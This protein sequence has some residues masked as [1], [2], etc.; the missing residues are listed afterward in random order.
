LVQK[1]RRQTTLS[2]D[3]VQDL[4][5]VRIDA[6][7]TLHEQTALANEIA[8]HF[9]E[10]SRVKDLREN[11]HSGYR[12]VHVW[13][14]L[15]AGRAEIQVRTVM[16]SAWANMYEALGDRFGRG[17]R[18]DEEAPND[19]AKLAVETMHT[20]SDSLASIENSR[21]HT[22]HEIKPKVAELRAN[23]DSL[24]LAQRLV[25]LPSVFRLR[26]DLRSLEGQTANM[27]VVWDTN[28]TE[29]VEKLETTRRRLMNSKEA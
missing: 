19:L 18:Y 20:L 22:V 10:P 9:G 17:I 2:L 16:Q 13:V 25:A 11:P 26:S 8:A 7:I 12:A 4:A 14:R 28:K 21:A 27:D 6:D 29:F 23:L 15:P 5:G 24:S 3:E 1:L